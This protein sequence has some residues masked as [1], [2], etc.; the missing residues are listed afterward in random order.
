MKRDSSI[1][2]GDG[3]TGLGQ[4]VMDLLVAVRL[5]DGRDVG[6]CT[7]ISR[8]SGSVAVPLLQVGPCEMACTAVLCNSTSWQRKFRLVGL[9][10][11]KRC[12]GLCQTL[13]CG[14]WVPRVQ[15]GW[16][17]MSE[18]SAAGHWWN[19]NSSLAR[20]RHKDEVPGVR[21]V[22]VFAETSCH[23]FATRSAAPTLAPLHSHLSLA[24]A[25]P[26]RPQ[27][28]RVAPFP[29]AARLLP[30]PRRLPLRTQALWLPPP[31]ASSA[32]NA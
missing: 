9:S 18:L 19:A 1:A 10:A 29:A 17:Q 4:L 21:H 3:W 5:G 20:R 23:A 28:S 12:R 14:S 6:G 8:R 27:P 26:P 30:S 24:R 15:C 16:R 2:G 7:L 32:T 25:D 22:N 31:A 13:M 11:G